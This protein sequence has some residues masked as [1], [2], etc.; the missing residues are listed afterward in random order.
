[1]TIYSGIFNSVNGDRKYNAWWF[2]KY[3][4]TFIGN[5]V[6]PNPSTNLQVVSNENMK[7]VVKPG[8]GW[9]DGYFIFS[10]G[11]HILSLDVADGVL[12]PIDRVVMRL[13]HLTRKIEIVVKK[14]TFASS[15]VAPV[16]QRDGNAYELAL[17]DVFVAN[18]ATQI[19]QANITDNRLNNALCGIVHGTVNQVDTTTLFNQY[20]SWINQQKALYT[21]E[22]ELW[23]ADQRLS[24]EQWMAT[25]HS[26]FANWRQL[27][28]QEFMDW[29]LMQQASF[30][31]W[32]LQEQTDFEAW[33]A[34]LEDLLDENIAAT[35]TAKIVTLEQNFDAHI[36]ESASTTNKGHVQLEDT[37]TSTST[38]KAA[39]ANAVKQF[40]DAVT[41]VDDALT[42]HT[43]D[44]TSHVHFGV[45][46]EAN[47]K[48]ITFTPAPTSLSM[49]FAVA[50]ANTV[51]NTGAVTLNVNNLGAV[52]VLNA[53]GEQL[54]AGALQANSICTVRYNNGNFI[55]QGD[56]GD[57][58]DYNKKLKG[59]TEVVDIT[60][61]YTNNYYLYTVAIGTKLAV[62][63]I[64]NAQVGQA[65]LYNLDDFTVTMSGI[66]LPNVYDMYVS[67]D[68]QD[69]YTSASGA[70]ARYINGGK[71]QLY[72]KT[73]E[74]V[75]NKNF[76]RSGKVS[77]DNEGHIFMHSA[78]V[79]YKVNL[80]DGVMIKKYT[81]PTSQQISDMLVDPINK[82]I[83]I[84]NTVYAVRKLNFDLELVW[85]KTATTW[86]KVDANDPNYMLW[87]LD[88]N[89]NP[90]LEYSITG[91]YY[92]RFTKFNSIDGSV[93]NERTISD[94]KAQVYPQFSNTAF[95]RYANNLVYFDAKKSHA[96][97]ENKFDFLGSSAK[98]WA[99]AP[100]ITMVRPS[101]DGKTLGA[102]YQGS[103][104]MIFLEK[105]MYKIIEGGQ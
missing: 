104:G 1:M 63:T 11:D 39:T 17:A 2:A 37:V 7:V 36:N 28:E 3:F 26:D 76:S 48:T 66:N 54:K 38:S 30:N 18:G 99:V 8:S 56:G 64:G 6:F 61:S 13:N 91:Y 68:D 15:P 29:M 67:D 57:S 92:L 44:F 86:K 59:L 102:T 22:L 33:V 20:Q 87:A 23:T 14:G 21:Q 5:G 47:V 71:T 49:G 19:T 27:E 89:G 78:H 60:E 97:N 50:F 62:T 103:N 82:C 94:N 74:N 12:K 10:D 46:T 32:M 25:Q 40:N 41:Q 58:F 72:L 45:T 51:A 42:T 34:T 80:A 93:I 65:T 98:T 77:I 95:N 75:V 84:I 24:F 105:L 101:R 83:Y 79:V 70:L 43:D 31:D 4:A 35:L 69:V 52:P 73:V 90:V 9:I 55:L 100:G 85:E 16:L 53:K 96:F 88:S 81:S